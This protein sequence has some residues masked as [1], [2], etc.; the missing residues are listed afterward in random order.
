MNMVSFTKILKEIKELKI[1]GAQAIARSALYALKHKAANSK[2]ITKGRFLNELGQAK[3][4]LFSSRSTEPCMRNCLNFVLIHLDGIDIKALKA[5]FYLRLEKALLHLEL[6]EQRIADIGSQKIR[7]GITVFTHCHSSTVINILK[8]AKQQN[9]HFEVHNTET[10]PKFQGRITAQELSKL[11][12]PVTHFVDAAARYALKKSDIMLIGA[13]A[14]TS[15]GKVINK[16]GSELFAE[17]AHKFEIPVYVC[18][19]SWKFDPASVFGYEEE[20]EVRKAAEIWSRPPK[21][22]HIHNYAFEK[23]DA[24]LITGIISEI[25]IYR[26]E[27]FVEELR[28][29]YGWMFR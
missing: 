17:I 13:D 29:N 25:G 6:T 14:I 19:D 15:E 10:R 5:E 28:R 24:E 22:V 8:K 20:L 18:T 9:K 3:S 27:I 7:S 11:G 1:Q 4:L 23:I 21:G 16:I 12:I 26:P 2:A